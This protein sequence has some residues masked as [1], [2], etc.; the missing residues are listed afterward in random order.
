M[1]F[2]CHI[3]FP[4][5][6]PSLPDGNVSRQSKWVKKVSA[7]QASLPVKLFCSFLW[8]LDCSTYFWND[9]HVLKRHLP[10]WCKNTDV[11]LGL[12]PLLNRAI[13]YHEVCV[14]GRGREEACGWRLAVS[15]RWKEK[16]RQLSMLYC[17]SSSSRPCYWCSD[18]G[19]CWAKLLQNKRCRAHRRK[20]VYLAPQSPE[21]E[22]NTSIHTLRGYFSSFCSNRLFLGTIKCIPV[23][24]KPSQTVFWE[25]LCCFHEKHGRMKSPMRHSG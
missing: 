8:L 16:S 13:M 1:T 2:G 15:D 9:W 10:G 20:N 24:W 12:G 18:S 5:F 6:F 11:L 17:M 7:R 4:L 19:R 3:C 21:T 22:N 14:P 25:F 23:A